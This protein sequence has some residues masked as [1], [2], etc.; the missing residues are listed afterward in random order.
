MSRSYKK[1]NYSGEP[2]GKW[3]KRRANDKVRSY[4]RKN[5]DAKISRG[6]YRKIQNPW[7]ICEDYCICSWEN[8]WKAELEW[9]E[10]FKAKGRNIQKPDKKQSYREW[11]TRYKMK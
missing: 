10:Y 5:V 3:K 2:K 8:Y 1:T 6:D 9:Y 4:F 11:Y 7:D